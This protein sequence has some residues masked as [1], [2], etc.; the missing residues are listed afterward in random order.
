MDRIAPAADLVSLKRFLGLDTLSADQRGPVYQYDTLFLA[1]DFG[2]RKDAH[3]VSQFGIS[4]LDTRGLPFAPLLGQTLVETQLYC[5]AKRF[6]HRRLVKKVK[7]VFSLGEVKWIT[8]EEKV[9]TLA[10]I[11]QQCNSYSIMERNPAL[12]QFRPAHV[13][14]TASRNIVLVGHGLSKE[15][16]NM[17][18]LGFR[19]EAYAN[20]I[21]YV[22]IRMLCQDVRGHAGT[23][24]SIVRHAGLCP[25][26]L[27]LAGAFPKARNFHVAGNDAAYN[28]EAL[29]LLV[30]KEHAEA[31][32]IDRAGWLRL[33]RM[34]VR[35][36][37][38]SAS[39]QLSQESGPRQKR[40]WCEEEQ[41]DFSVRPPR[42]RQALKSPIGVDQSVSQHSSEIDES[43]NLPQQCLGFSGEAV[44]PTFLL[45]AARWQMGKEA[46]QSTNIEEFDAQARAAV[47]PV[48]YSTAI[49]TMPLFFALAPPW[50]VTSVRV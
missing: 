4:I 3:G 19:P 20:I 26:K 7:K 9:P 32:D 14:L 10:T 17:D 27:Y 23:L 8:R 28:L 35:E 42:R 47:G 49:C 46:A 18:L 1:I 50:Q 30:A 34:S 41:S 5:V 21:A 24:R 44:A 40:K 45:A 31:V 6:K 15:L 25:K 36:A 16:R 33:T 37:T 43:G 12:S 11:F 2:G 39:A 38:A 13:P 48:T 29:L 22:D